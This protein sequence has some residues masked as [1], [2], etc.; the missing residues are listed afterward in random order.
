MSA[1]VQLSKIFSTSVMHGFQ[2]RGYQEQNAYVI[3]QQ[4]E[5]DTGTSVMTCAFKTSS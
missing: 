1:V 3:S 5:E 4:E 2:I